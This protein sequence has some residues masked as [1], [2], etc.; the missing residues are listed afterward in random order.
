[1]LV[2]QR[3]CWVKHCNYIQTHRRRRRHRRRRKPHHTAIGPD[4]MSDLEK[5][6]VFRQAKAWEK[7]DALFNPVPDEQQGYG[8]PDTVE[9]KRQ[10]TPGERKQTAR[11]VPDQA[12][13]GLEWAMHYTVPQ[14]M[15][16]IVDGWKLREESNG[17]V[18]I[19]MYW[20]MVLQARA[21]THWNAV[22]NEHAKEA[23]S[24]TFELW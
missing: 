24:R 18:L 5:A 10:T 12:I 1:M 14:F 19:F 13:Q 20:S 9:V 3:S 4:D 15:N 23:N 22:V 11:I 6:L 2:N 21:L 7:K 16:K 8:Q 17:G